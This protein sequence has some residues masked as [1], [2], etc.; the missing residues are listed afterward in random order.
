MKKQLI[1]NSKSLK[2]NISKL[3]KT[4]SLLAIA[5]ILS[6]TSLTAL[7]T[8]KAGA[9]SLPNMVADPSF[10]IGSGFQNGNNSISVTAI[11]PDGK[12]LVGGTFTSFN[13]STQNCLI[14][15]NSDGSKDTSFDIG[16]GFDNT[17]FSINVQS[18]GKI[19]AGGQFTSFNGSTQNR[20]IR[21]NA[22]GSK[23][24]SFDIGTGFGN[25]VQSVMMQ[26]N[27]KIVVSGFFT[28]FNGS[29][30][31][32]LIR[33]NAD[34]SKDTSFD[35]G[36]G[37]NGAAYSTS[38]QP[39][40]KALVG[41]N[42]TSF[43]GSTQNRLIRLNADGSKDTSFDV[44]SG[45][46]NWVYSSNIQ[47]D[48]KI[49]VG[50]D[51]ASYNGSAQNYLVRL[52]SDGTKDS[53]F[54]IGSGI[55]NTP[56]SITVQ[57]N[58]KLIL[59]GAFTSYNGSTQN[60]LI[61]L[62]ADGSKDTSFDIGSGLNGAAYSTSIQPDGKILVGGDFTSYRGTTQ[63]YLIR[64][65]S[66]GSKDTS[67]DIGTGLN[68]AVN[69]ITIQPDSKILVG[70]AFTSFNGST[71]NRLI[72]LN[73]D[74]S[75]DSS[76]D[77][78]T[79]LNEAVNTTTIQPDGKILVG[80]AFTSFN[81]ST[82]N[83][84]IR[85]NSD[86]SKDS[87]F[88]IGTGFDSIVWSTLIQPDGNLVIAGGFLQYNGST[89]MSYIRLKP[90][91]AQDNS[92]GITGFTGPSGAIITI[93]LQSDGK[94][95][96]G[97]NFTT[98][99]SSTQNYLIRFNPDGSKDTSFDVGTGFNS[100]I[101]AISLQPDGKIVVGGAFTSYNGSTQNRLIRLNKD[102]TKDNSFSIDRGFDGITRVVIIQPDSKILVGGNFTTY[103]NQ[104]QGG[105]V[106]LQ[107]TPDRDADGLLDTQEDSSPNSG[108]ANQDGT[109]DSLQNN[110]TSYINP[111]TNQ[112]TVLQVDS[113]CSLSNISTKDMSTNTT[114]DTNYSYPLG[115]YDFTA[116]CG[117][118]GH[119]TSFKAY[120]YSADTTKN[121]SL[122]KYNPNTNTYTTIDNATFTTETIANQSVLTASYTITDGSSLD[123]DGL[124]NGIIVDPAGP[125]LASTTTNS[126]NTPG[127]PNTGVGSST[128]NQTLLTAFI[129][130]NTIL[131]AIIYTYKNRKQNYDQQKTI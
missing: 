33:L 115:L 74:G 9:T 106:R 6:V 47:Q 16:S 113:Q 125:A 80:G 2:I 130:L 51:L 116:S 43:N 24:T 59:G 57:S 104:Y 83:R 118:P 85:L 7:I 122:R 91:G 49:L 87:S 105:L 56:Y 119:S 69:T 1:S 20:L 109:L 89:K 23:D 34:G 127:A 68:G 4:T 18:N 40:G 110:V 36:S 81:G 25:N 67:F 70:G 5:L 26:S 44:G 52:N 112:T 45:F 8:P 32:R 38:I 82:Q 19:L 72:R 10:D 3:Y 86:G 60:R 54:N 46:S 128:N 12:I 42:F 50:S 58:N 121:Y 65:N 71:Q 61:R 53:S 124:V 48:G 102:G 111:I 39:D 94:I 75:K 100:F 29:T 108:D 37:L 78:G 96:A 129:I 98:F 126:T 117:T 22:D 21:L 131:T 95:L 28:S 55:N 62:N 14:R 76:F 90:N 88:D 66:D 103:N 30:Q 123:T 114:Q 13:G 79:G 97:G 41:G 63:N 107:L 11:Q 73:S 92:F 77:I 93:A 31:N 17:I 99:N 64:L 101:R 15:L 84:L 27:D 35:I 120:Y